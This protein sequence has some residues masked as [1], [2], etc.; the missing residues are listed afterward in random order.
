MV[1]STIFPMA[2]FAIL[3]VSH[4]ELN[5]ENTNILML[6]GVCL[7]SIYKCNLAGIF[8]IRFTMSASP[9]TIVLMVLSDMIHTALQMLW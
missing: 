3:T 1:E 2:D 4:H 7:F 8:S 6:A 5:D 9:S